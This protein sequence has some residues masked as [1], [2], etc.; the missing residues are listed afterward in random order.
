MSC[1]INTKDYFLRT[2]D[3]LDVSGESLSN[4]F[5]RKASGTSQGVSPFLNIPSG[6]LPCFFISALFN[7]E[8]HLITDLKGQFFEPVPVAVLVNTHCE[9]PLLR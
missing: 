7:W 4:C 6:T 5:L 3:E 9:S 8:T 1:K 2:L